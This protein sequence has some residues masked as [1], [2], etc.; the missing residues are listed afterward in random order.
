[1]HRSTVWRIAASLALAGTVVGIAPIAAQASVAPTVAAPKVLPAPTGVTATRDSSKPND[2]RV[3]WKTV[4]G[5]V[6]HYNVSVKANGRDDVTIVRGGTNKLDVTGV[7]YKTTYRITVS[8]RDVAG[9]GTTSGTVVLNPV[10]PG[11][12]TGFK[13]ARSSTLT[14]MSASWVAPAWA[15]YGSFKGYAV[16][17]KRLSDAKLIIDTT[18]SNTSIKATSLDPKRTYSLTVTPVN[19]YGTG[20]AVAT[21]LNSAVPGSP[22]GTVVVRD[23]KD[24]AIVHVTWKAPAWTGTSDITGY[25]VVYGS[26][27]LNRMLKSKE[28]T[29]DVT[30]PYTITGLVAVRACNGSGCGY[31]GTTAKA[32]VK[33]AVIPQGEATSTNPFVGIEEKDGT[34]T[35]ETRDTI[36]STALYPRLFVQVKPTMANGGFTDSQW[37]QN[38][39]QV[40]T[41]GIVPTGTYSTYVYGVAADGKQTELARKVHV[42]GSAGE[43][44]SGEWKVIRGKADI[45]GNR[46]DMP[47]D[48]ENRVMSTRKRTS[49]DMVLSTTATLKSGWGYGVWFRS[50]VDSS[51]LVSGYTFQ[52]DPKYGN[53]FILRH[54]SKG[55]E[56]GTPLA[57]TP[58]PAGFKENIAHHVV[59]VAKGDTVWASV[60]G[61]EI[62]RVNS[63]AAA[64]K[65]SPCA[66]PAP[67]G[68]GIGFRT[69]STSP[70]FFVGT[71]LS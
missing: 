18:T 55:S 71:T 27:T 7:D 13:V 45:K 54:W 70:S 43:L 47:Y 49:Q 28:L 26:N 51:N 19:G 48:G 38:G 32:P 66:Y 36:G 23:E 11:A 20:P 14:D 67:T 69:W 17:L 68:T 10:V 61:Q 12:P 29:A 53:K 41:F 37:G 40:M 16:Q 24:P 60:D 30:I 64:I 46:I 2:F 31:L 22:T 63:L 33:G 15:G 9:L 1:M 65:A 21:N 52:Y 6:D 57:A 3:E 50:S 62:F 25:E 4:P 59:V 44:E 39:A 5:A 8:S 56:C 58:F 34:I 35:V 42:I